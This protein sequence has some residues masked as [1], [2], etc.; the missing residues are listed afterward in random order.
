MAAFG[1]KPTLPIN[2]QCCNEV[3]HCGHSYRAQHFVGLNVDVQ[4]LRIVAAR[5]LMQSLFKRT[6][7][8]APDKLEMKN[9][10]A[11]PLGLVRTSR[12][13]AVLLRAGGRNY[14]VAQS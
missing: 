9:L 13:L 1:P 5:R 12:N 3:R 14:G 7:F 11:D 8:N 10:T 4:T 6:Q 2:S